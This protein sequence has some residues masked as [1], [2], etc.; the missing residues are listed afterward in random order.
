VVF[1]YLGKL[2]LPRAA[3][4]SILSSTMIFVGYNPLYSFSSSGIDNAAHVGGLVTGVL[5]G[6]LLTR[7]LPPPEGFSRLPKAFI[8]VGLVLLL[9][10]GTLLVRQNSKVGWSER[11]ETQLPVA[12]VSDFGCAS[13]QPAC[14]AHSRHRGKWIST[15][16]D[17]HSSAY[18]LQ[19]Q[20]PV[21]GLLFRAI[22]QSRP[23]S[24]ILS[25]QPLSQKADQE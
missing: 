21:G 6:A 4:Q 12:W 22:R 5:V 16:G 25:L 13:T 18:H 19:C 9:V 2:P 3:T 11:S 17:K 7:P 8:A 20:S 23:A 14:L 1:L 24:C 10:V 15:S